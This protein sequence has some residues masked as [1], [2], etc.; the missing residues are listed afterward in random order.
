[1]IRRPPRSTLFPYTTLFRSQIRGRRRTR[2]SP[3]S[4]AVFRSPVA[5]PCLELLEKRR[6]PL[7]LALRGGVGLTQVDRLLRLTSHASNHAPQ[8]ADRDNRC[9]ER[10]SG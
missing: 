8:F 3:R 9:D 6:R 2:R 1:M 4:A 5:L 10:T 7:A